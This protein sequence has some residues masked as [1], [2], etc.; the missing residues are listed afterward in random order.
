MGGAGQA[1]PELAFDDAEVV[2]VGY[3]IQADEEGWDDYKGEDV[4]GKVLLMLNGDPYWDPELFAGERKLYY[5]RWW[6]KYEIAALQGAAAAVIVHTAP[7]AGYP[8]VVVRNGWN[9]EQFRLAEEK[10]PKVLL[11]SWLTEE[12]SRRLVDL[13]GHDLDDLMARARSRDFRPVPLGV[14]TSLAFTTEIR[15]TESAN[16]AGLLPGSDPALAE[17]VLIFS[18]HHD[19]FG[20]GEPDEN[21][22]AIYNGALDNGVAMAQA[23]EVAEA[24]AS[25]TPRPRRS[26]M[27]LFVAAEEQGLLG[28]RYFA[29]SN[30]YPP[31]LIAANINF[32]LG[33]VWGP[34]RDITIYGKGK[35]TLEDSLV[36]LDCPF[37]GGPLDRK[38]T[39][40]P[41]GTTVRTS[42]AS[43]A[44]VCPPSGS[45]RERSSSANP[46]VGARRP[47]PPGFGSDTIAPATRCHRTGIWK[48]WRRMPGW[49]SAWASRSPTQTSC[50][51]GTRETSSKTSARK[52][53][54]PSSQGQ[55][56]LQECY[57]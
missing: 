4:Q 39:S 45:S 1:L 20:V 15:E 29:Q 40:E 9:G 48:V 19:H 5:G 23:L 54:P 57:P 6:Y 49:P 56:N 43:L 42:S 35:S 13:G 50:P 44:S 8:W 14:T 55:S 21:G 52:H 18:A 16:V 30:R 41:A 3:G 38:R 47:T 53:S 11:E 33:N 32:E 7:S 10:S 17:Q 25:L 12:A 34:T 36:E 37:R 31:G 2:F 27:F 46:M 22:D 28:S 51:P 24:F 26:V